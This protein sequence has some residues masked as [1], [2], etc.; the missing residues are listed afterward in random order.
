VVY[1]ALS[2]KVKVEL[3][4]AAGHPTCSKNGVDMLELT[5]ELHPSLASTVKL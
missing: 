4:A 5:K 1:G 2:D 3:V